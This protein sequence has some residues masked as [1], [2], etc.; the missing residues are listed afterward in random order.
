MFRLRL[1]AVPAVLLVSALSVGACTPTVAGRAVRAAGYSPPPP[2][3]RDLL[4]QDGEQTPFG[5]ARSR[6]V[7]GSYFTSVR[8]AE[9]SAALLFK[10]SPLRPPGSIDAAESAYGFDGRARYAESI[11]RYDRDVD[12]HEVA[13]RAFSEVSDC[14]VDAIGVSPWR[15]FKPMRVTGFDI[16]Q[17]NVM[18]WSMGRED[19]TCSYGLAAVSRVVL[20]IAACDAKP[21]F[22]MAEWGA[23]RKAQLDRRPT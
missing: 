7:D 22:P 20:M 14:R 17:D 9:C 8:P 6:P 1:S 15:E 3:A 4:L 13:W 11:D 23:K 21:D 19:W 18:T 10:G 12:A 5:A 16:P 2:A